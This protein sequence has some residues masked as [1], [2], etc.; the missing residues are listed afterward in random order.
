VT[1]KK[2]LIIS[3]V[4]TRVNPSLPRIRHSRPSEMQ[5]SLYYQLLLNMIDGIVDISRL[6]SELKLD[7][8]LCFSDG[9]LAEAGELYSAAGVLSFDLLMENNTLNVFTL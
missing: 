4:K 2:R 9:F 3:D 8:D 6:F 1:R 7:T 5:L